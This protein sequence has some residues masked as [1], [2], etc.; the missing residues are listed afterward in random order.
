MKILVADKFEP[1][2]IDGLKAL[3]ASVVYE[4][5]GGAEKLGPTL[6]AAAPDVLI[7]R[8]TKVKA[9]TIAM[10][11][12]LRVIIRAGVGGGQHRRARRHPPRHRGDEHAGR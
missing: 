8:S 2:G 3:G 12:G 6:A 7:V 10:A 1:A 11:Q 4:P 9:D 5:G